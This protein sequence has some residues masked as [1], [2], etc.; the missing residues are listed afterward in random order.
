[1]ALQQHFSSQL[2]EV[3]EQEYSEGCY[4]PSLGNLP[5]LRI[6]LV[7]LSPELVGGF[8]NNIA[9]SEASKYYQHFEESEAKQ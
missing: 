3:E 2:M 4:F 6:K 1:M 9:I 7:S 8:F 5:N